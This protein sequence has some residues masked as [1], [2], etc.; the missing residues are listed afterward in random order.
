MKDLYDE[1]T[2]IAR[3]T[4]NQKTWTIG[5]GDSQ[6]SV[7][8]HEAL[9]KDLNSFT[10]FGLVLSCLAESSKADAANDLLTQV[11]SRCRTAHET[12][13]TFLSNAQFNSEEPRNELDTQYRTYYDI[14][15][16]IAL[17]LPTRQLGLISVAA[18]IKMAMNGP[19]PASLYQGNEKARLNEFRQCDAPDHRLFRIASFL[20]EKFWSRSVEIAR[21]HF[22]EHPEW[23]WMMTPNAMSIRPK[24][25]QIPGT[26]LV[27][28]GLQKPSHELEIAIA[29]VFM[30]QI[31]ECGR[32]EG[33]EFYTLQERKELEKRMRDHFEIQFSRPN[34]MK[35]TPGDEFTRFEGESLFLRN[36]PLDANMMLA[37]E[38]TE[39]SWNGYCK[40]LQSES[41]LPVYFRLFDELIENHTFDAK[42]ESAQSSA[43]CFLRKKSKNEKGDL[44]V[45][46]HLLREAHE[47]IKFGVMSEM[48]RADIGFCVSGRALVELDLA[49][50]EDWFLNAQG[51]RVSVLLNA[52][53]NA[54]VACIPPTWDFLAW[55]I[56]TFE[57]SSSPQKV[58]FVIPIGES[59]HGVEGFFGPCTDWSADDFIQK[60]DPPPAPLSVINLGIAI[61][62]KIY[63]Q[64]TIPES[65]AK[66]AIRYMSEEYVFDLGGA[67]A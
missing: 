8:H 21:K 49:S 54:T 48:G 36:S 58:L 29:A 24:F 46:I 44:V 12:Y 2:T 65:L 7:T 20:D 6:N 51:S 42:S 62:G 52:E 22:H 13:A 5:P 35:E 50:H 38:M 27:Q 53:P 59:D 45:D 63:P 26:E 37:S 67:N 55:H 1:V 16:E 15:N 43:A 60:F 4:F 9:H 10:T 11:V 40:I 30:D 33:L 47:L 41:L 31:G 56:H 57:N 34:D 3:G 17:K 39:D 61:N 66:T 19:L 25:E 32:A 18:T 23:G 28:F 14:G 64:T